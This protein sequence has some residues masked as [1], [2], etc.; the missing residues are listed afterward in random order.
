[1]FQL[2]YCNY[3]AVLLKAQFS[4]SWSK[5]EF[6][7][8]RRNSCLISSCITVRRAVLEVFVLIFYFCLQLNYNLILWITSLI[9]NHLF[10]AMPFYSILKL[11]KGRVISMK[12][13]MC[14]SYHYAEALKGC[15]DRLSLKRVDVIWF[16]WVIVVIVYVSCMCSQHCQ[17]NALWKP[18]FSAVKWHFFKS[19]NF[20]VAVLFC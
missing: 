19:C 12:C 10:L 17:C 18:L 8:E 5:E 14:L 16:N 1:M 13:R 6:C 20:S 7:L 3:E 9:K 4:S 2:W 15:W 11:S